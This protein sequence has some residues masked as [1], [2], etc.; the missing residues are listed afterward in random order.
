MYRIQ[1]SFS[2]TI[3]KP[4]ACWR[5]RPVGET[6]LPVARKF[7][8]FAPM[9]YPVRARTFLMYRSECTSVRARGKR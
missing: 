6:R 5:S 1:F 3:V 2:A 8:I 7:D 4:D 9:S